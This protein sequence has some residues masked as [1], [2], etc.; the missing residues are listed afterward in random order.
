M[1]KLGLLRVEKAVEIIGLDRAYCTGF[2]KKDLK[3]YK[4]KYE[5][6][7]LNVNE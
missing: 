5:K 6:D 7:N 4:K 1:K 3:K 2:S